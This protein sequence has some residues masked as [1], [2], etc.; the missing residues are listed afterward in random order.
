VP[1]T[2]GF[3]ENLRCHLLC[4]GYALIKVAEHRIHLEDSVP[5]AL[6]IQSE[7][8]I[9]GEGIQERIRSVY[10]GIIF[11][12]TEGGKHLTFFHTTLSSP[13]SPSLWAAVDSQSRENRADDS[14]SSC[15]FWFPFQCHAVV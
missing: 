5:L 9:L 12:R 13:I 4:K 10:P 11:P 14:K 15:G 8:T 3:L 2:T 7:V 1:K 6:W